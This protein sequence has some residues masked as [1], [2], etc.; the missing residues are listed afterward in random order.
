[1]WPSG[2]KAQHIFPRKRYKTYEYILELAV[3]VLAGR[4]TIVKKIKPLVV[5]ASR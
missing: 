2:G 5:V 3:T 4:S 1:M